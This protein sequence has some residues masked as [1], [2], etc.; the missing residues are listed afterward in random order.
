M[1]A[2]QSDVFS[3]PAK[4][5]TILTLRAEADATMRTLC[6]TNRSGSALMA[7]IEE[8]ADGVTWSVVVPP[9][10]IGESG[11][12]TATVVKDTASPHMLRI[13]A[14]GGKNS[15]ELEL[16]YTRLKDSQARIWA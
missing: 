1:L 6:F 9:F 3:I 16:G 2:T 8:S 5:K 4:E 12:E 10:T 14:A 15:Q 11:S 7:S 13:R